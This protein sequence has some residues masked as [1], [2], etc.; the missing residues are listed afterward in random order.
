MSDDKHLFLAHD[1]MATSRLRHVC[2][3]RCRN[4]PLQTCS[5]IC[6]VIVLI[7]AA[8][9]TLERP[10]FQY[11][12]GPFEKGEIYLQRPS[13]QAYY[14]WRILMSWFAESPIEI[15]Y[16]L[17]HPGWRDD[18]LTKSDHS[19]YLRRDTS[20]NTKKRLNLFLNHK[21]S[22]S[23]G[24]TLKATQDHASSKEYT[25]PF[26]TKSSATKT[27]ASNGS[28]SNQISPLSAEGKLSPPLKTSS[29]ANDPRPSPSSCK[30]RSFAGTPSTSGRPPKVARS[31]A[32]ETSSGKKNSILYVPRSVACN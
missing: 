15:N 13:Q 1:P 20:S 4:Y 2:Y 22:S 28:C 3:W 8:V 25:F 12:I 17:L 9:A 14:F 11:L 6:G 19:F 21:A 5:D 23:S 7:N 31:T 10:L 26:S 24:S 32:D 27:E 16:V 18:I 29:T 30:K